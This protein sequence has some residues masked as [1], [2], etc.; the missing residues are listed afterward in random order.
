MTASSL[1]D[2]TITNGRVVINWTASQ[3]AQWFAYRIYHQSAEDDQIWTLVYE[4]VTAAPSYSVNIY[5]YSN[6]ITQRFTV[7][8]VTTEVGTGRILEGTYGQY[9]E[10]TPDSVD[11]DYWL[12]H[13]NPALSIRFDNVVSDDFTDEWERHEF[14]LLGRGRKVNLGSRIGRV[15]T[16][17]IQMRDSTTGTARAKRKE[18]TDLYA[19]GDPVWLRDPFGDLVKIAIGEPSFNRIPGLALHEAVNVNLPYSEVI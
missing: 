10:F 15:G 2:Q 17:E 14:K 1:L 16:L 13:T 4:T 8:E 5:Q 9:N 6:A 18:L 19:L 12:I 11:A 7:V 3:G